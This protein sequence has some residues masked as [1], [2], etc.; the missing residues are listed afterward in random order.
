[1]KFYTQNE[2]TIM[3]SSWFKFNWRLD[4]TKIIGSQIAF[5]FFIIQILLD[6]S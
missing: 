3:Y 4:T 2:S 5:A 1:M 6:L